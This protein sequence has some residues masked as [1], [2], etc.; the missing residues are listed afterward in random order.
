MHRNKACVELFLGVYDAAKTDALASLLN[1][2]DDKSKELDSKA[3]YRAG[4][5][6]YELADYQAAKTMFDRCLQV[7]PHDTDGLRELK[8]TICRITEEQDGHFDFLAMSK[9]ITTTKDFRAKQAS[10]V[11]RTEIKQTED[12]GKGLFTTQSIACGDIVLC[13]KAFVAA[14]PPWLKPQKLQNFIV[15]PSS[16]HVLM[17]GHPETWYAAVKKVF[18]N[19]SLASRLLGLCAWSGYNGNSAH[20]QIS[21]VPIVDNL[22]VVDVFHILAVL[23][24]NG[25]GFMARQDQTQAYPNVPRPQLGAHYDCLGVWPV[26][27]RTNHSCL[28]NAEYS[29][30][31]DFMIV[32]AN[33]DILK[34]EEITICYVPTTGKFEH[35]KTALR[36]WNFKCQCK[37]CHAET[38]WGGTRSP[39]LTGADSY[40]EAE[41]PIAVPDKRILGLDKRTEP[42][43]QLI[44]VVKL[45]VDQIQETYPAALFSDLPTIGLAKRH[46]WLMRAYAM[47]AGKYF[48]STF[49][50]SQNAAMMYAQAVIRD[51]GFVPIIET[52][53]KKISYNRENILT[54][55]DLEMGILRG[56]ML[57]REL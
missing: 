42:A 38:A 6:L 1:Q 22:P 40:E 56:N 55:T 26:A 3:L 14:D 31:G 28:T 13:E 15:S 24:N 43:D 34:G 54:T 27:S 19:P 16:K 30:L 12:R 10:Y 37:L 48:G 50:V 35:Q 36:N 4:R 20:Q 7:L 41:S 44:N 32:R 21:F 45:Y 11:R 46:A 17:S 51:H 23:E 57:S 8:H 9:N 49:A 5:A 33:K 18:N 39:L 29:F 52:V 47:G 25:L 53:G 2:P